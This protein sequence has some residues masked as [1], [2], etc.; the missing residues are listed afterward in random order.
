[1]LEEIL[2]H[3]DSRSFSLPETELPNTKF[4]DGKNTLKKKK[5]SLYVNFLSLSTATTPI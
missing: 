2:E 5:K 3:S 4:P 1:M